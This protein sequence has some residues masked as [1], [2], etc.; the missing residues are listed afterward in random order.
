VIKIAAVIYVCGILALQI[1]PSG[2]IDKY[3]GWGAFF[4]L[5]IWVAKE[6]FRRLDKLIDA[7]NAGS[8][9]SK[10]EHAKTRALIRSE[11]R[12]E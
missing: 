7:V 8:E 3:G 10:E 2:L 1:E 5:V 11:R 9:A 12:E 4:V 6:G